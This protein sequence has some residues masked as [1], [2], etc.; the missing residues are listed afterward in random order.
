MNLSVFRN[1]F[2]SQAAHKIAGTSPQLLH[3]LV[4]K[5]L[6]GN[7]TEGKCQMHDLVHQYSLEKLTHTQE[8]QE[9]T[10]CQLHCDYFLERV[11]GWAK[12]LKSATTV[13]LAFTG[14]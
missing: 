13:G 1:P 9:I 3:T 12:A 5:S 10:I 11:A 8:P 7:T 4:G 6:L 14:R 2:T